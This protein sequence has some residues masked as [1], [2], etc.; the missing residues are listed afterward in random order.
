MARVWP[1]AE[2]G[3]AYLLRENDL[4]VQLPPAEIQDHLID[5]YFTYVH[6]VIPVVHKAHF[7][8][9]YQARCVNG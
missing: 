9:E 2:H 4:K 6:P 3:A 7:M 5:L 1:P 8:A